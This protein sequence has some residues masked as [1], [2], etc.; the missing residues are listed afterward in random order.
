[1]IN[2]YHFSNEHSG[3]VHSFLICNCTFR[4][5]I[6]NLFSQTN[7][8]VFE[9]EF[10]NFNLET[11]FF[12]WPFT[13]NKKVNGDSFC[14]LKYLAVQSPDGIIMTLIYRR[15]DH[16]VV[17]GYLDSNFTRLMDTKKYIWLFIS[18]NWRSN[19]M[20]KC[21]TVYHCC[22]HYESWVCG[23]LWCH[24]SWFTVAKLYF[25]TWNCR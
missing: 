18:F 21:E 19:L 14:F 24:C 25:M 5:K 13:P 4:L 20:D 23:L 6:S 2:W 22:I 8:T 3:G 9:L 17:I 10:K 16:L 12:E 7:Q 1:M 15:S 11:R